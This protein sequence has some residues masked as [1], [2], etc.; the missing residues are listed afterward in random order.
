MGAEERSWMD[1]PHGEISDR[2]P[3]YSRGNTPAGGSEKMNPPDRLT[4]RTRDALLEFILGPRCQP[5]GVGEGTV[6]ELLRLEWMPMSRSHDIGLFLP[7][8]WDTSR[9]T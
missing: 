4:R 7:R 3:F 6:R 2:M 1:S 9:D 8:H 5:A